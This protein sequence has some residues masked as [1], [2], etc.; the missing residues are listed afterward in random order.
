MQIPQKF[1]FIKLYIWKFLWDLYMFFLFAKIACLYIHTS[2]KIEKDSNS[3]NDIF[4]L[5]KDTWEMAKSDGQGL[6]YYTLAQ[7]LK[8]MILDG[9]IQAGERLPSENELSERY[10]ISRHTV[11]KALS[12]LANEGYIYAE[13]GKGT[14]CSE[15]VRHTKTS[16]NIAVVTTY[17]SDYIFPKV[18]QGIDGIMAQKGY[19]IILKNTR[20]SRKAE[21]KCLEELLQKDI[22]GLIIEPS[23]SEIFCKH[24]SL[25]ERLEQFGIPYVFIQ[26]CYEQMKEKPQVRM[27]DCKG[28]YLVTNHLITLGHKKILGVFKADDAQGRERH[29]GYVQALQ[30]AGILYDPDNI[31]WFHTE[32]RAIK[33]FAALQELVR[34]ER[35]FDAVVCYNDQI[36]VEIV[37]ALEECHIKVPEQVS[38]T[39]YDNS[40]IAENSRIKLTTIAHP[41]DKLGEM[42]AKLLLELIQNP[43]ASLQESRIFIDPEL[44]V[45]DSCR[46]RG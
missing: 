8:R 7:D 18:V 26:G 10:Q 29:R 32:D 4:E 39:G 27:D 31:I 15:L 38:V 16:R 3:A 1:L 37:K 28:G 35:E 2:C 45:R 46:K 36:A 22:E 13:H 21:A 19:S 14:F 12:I 24:I 43:N 11:R 9:G 25:Y 20:N 30:E 42:A 6:K 33:P 17:L 40:F 5:G 23:K 41:Q 44:I 34:Q